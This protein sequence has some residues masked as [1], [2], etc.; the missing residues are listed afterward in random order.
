MRVVFVKDG[1]FNKTGAFAELKDGE[2]LSETTPLYER[3]G[4][5][6]P[7]L[8]CEDVA[9]FHSRD[10]LYKRKGSGDDKDS[11]PLASRSIRATGYI[12]RSR[13]GKHQIAMLGSD[14]MH[15]K[16]NF[17]IRDV[18]DIEGASAGGSSAINDL[19]LN[20]DE[21]FY[22]EAFLPTPDFDGLLEELEKPGAT[23]RVHVELGRFPGFYA[24]WSPSIGEG[25][26]IKF[27]NQRA[28]VENAEEIPKDFVSGG[29]EDTALFGNSPITIYVSRKLAVDPLVKEDG[30]EAWEEVEN[31][32]AN[33]DETRVAGLR[34]QLKELVDAQRRVARNVIIGLA[35]VAAALLFNR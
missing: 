6:S 16:L 12:E 7:T 20:I 21:S 32:D 34:S 27:L 10:V 1:G 13:W 15:D 17:S 24:T 18:G 14:R 3:Q 35:L 19:D 33:Q 25:R 26:V 9:F 29:E 31:E 11:S 28:D 2:V 22:V 5:I 8:L 30:D 23:L 4:Y